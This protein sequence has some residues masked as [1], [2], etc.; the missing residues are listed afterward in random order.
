MIARERN[1]KEKECASKLEQ[2]CREV[3]INDNGS[4]T[5]MEFQEAMQ[6]KHIPLMLATLGLQRHH[7]LEFF[8]DMAETANDGG[9]VEITTFVNG[10]MLLRGAATN[11]D[12]Q[13]LHSDLLKLHADSAKHGNYMRDVLRLLRSGHDARHERI[14]DACVDS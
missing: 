1:L 11:F 4:L 2:F 10:C 5:R 7:V 13:K 9:Q 12:L 6:R 14:A 3:D 8:D